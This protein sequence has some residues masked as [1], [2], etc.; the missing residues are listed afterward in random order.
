S[1]TGTS[2][3]SAAK[4]PTHYTAAANHILKN[5]TRYLDFM[6]VGNSCSVNCVGAGMDVDVLARY[7]TVSK[8]FKGKIRYY[9]ALIDTLLHTKFHKV[10]ITEGGET[11]E[12]TVFLITAANGTCIGGGMPVSPNSDPYDGKFN[13]V[14]VEQVKKSKILGLLLKFLKGKHIDEPVTH[15]IITDKAII[16]VLDEGKCELDGEITD[17]QI[18][19]IQ[20]VTQTLK[21]FA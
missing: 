12:K 16:E 17:T 20:L 6:R 1:G 5:N 8:V 4:L 15:E 2:C 10:R 11:Y 9:V 14:Y 19:D 18:L 21:I 13:I 3:I 7:E